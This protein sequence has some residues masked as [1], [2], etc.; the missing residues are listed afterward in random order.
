M[1]AP[2]RNILDTTSYKYIRVFILISAPNNHWHYYQV[3]WID[4]EPE[5][6]LSIS[7]GFEVPSEQFRGL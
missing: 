3:I 1:V 7:N 4:I 5:A 6:I 2:V